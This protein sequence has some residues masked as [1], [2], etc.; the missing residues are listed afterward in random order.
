MNHIRTSILIPTVALLLLALAACTTTS[1][2]PPGTGNVNGYIVGLGDWS[3]FSPPLA[4]EAPHPDPDED[5]TV[6]ADATES[7]PIK[8]EDGEVVRD[9]TT[10]EPVG[11]EDV[12]YTCTTTPYNLTS[13][14]GQIVMYNPDASILWAGS[15]IQGESYARGIGG[16][17]GLTI[18]ERAPIEVV[19]T[20]FFNDN[21]SE[22]VANPSLGT[23][24]D[25][26][27]RMVGGATAENLATPSTIAFDM[28]TYHSE[29]DF[30]AAFNISGSYLGFSAAASGSIDNSFSKTTVA[31]NFRQQMF[32]VSVPPPQTPGSFFSSDFTQAKLQE[33]IDLGRIGPD[34]LPVYVSEIVYGRMMMFTLTSTASETELRAAISA[35]YNGIGSVSADLSASQRNVLDQS[36][37]RITSFGGEADATI[38][39][40]R[41]G[42]W[43]DYFTNSAPLTSAKPLS[44]TFRNLSDGSIAKVSETGSYNIRECSARI[45]SPGTFDFG[46]V[47]RTDD[48]PIETPYQTLVGDFDGD[49]HDDLLFNHLDPSSNEL[50]LAFGTGLGTFDLV[51][52]V[53]NPAADPDDPENEEPPFIDVPIYFEAHPDT[54]A[55]GWGNY[56]TR[57]MD[58]DGDDLDDVVWNVHIS[59]ANKTYA[60]IATVDADG[61]F[62]GFDFTEVS[63]HW[64]SAANGWELY[65]LLTGDINGDDRGDLVWHYRASDRTYVGL[66]NGDGSFD[67][68]PFQDGLTISSSAYTPFIGDVNGDIYADLLV[69]NGSGSVDKALGQPDGTFVTSSS[70]GIF[71]SGTPYAANIDANSSTDIV[72]LGFVFA[73]W[74]AQVGFADGG[75]DFDTSS[76]QQLPFV[77]DEDTVPPFFDPY[78]QDVNGDGNDDLIYT[79]PGNAKVFGESSNIKRIFVG[80][81]TSND[82][83]PFDISRIHQDH[84]QFLNWSTYS[85]SFGDV[86]GDGLTDIIWVFEGS[87][88]R[89]LVG[90]AKNE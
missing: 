21:P 67:T 15:L 90:L 58:I 2:P 6:L 43:R 33:Q 30:A 46:V 63:P 66:S 73:H 23:V 54:A 76:E 80:L 13:N 34:N 72:Y 57:I 64:N 75:G 11:F 89:I 26:I 53:P 12:T 56:E 49:D 41:S 14:P 45:A 32:T 9:D 24:T 28:Q 38:A 18:A 52:P 36:E 59:G 8:D 25:A 69:V 7:T 79:G 42:N 37:V 83:E 17:E 35:A 68:L 3:D 47:Q 50:M 78:F 39:M 10:G 86:N 85:T 62:A 55:E 87:T 1:G 84:P 22:V 71:S 31:V 20:D 16:L 44:Y 4:D 81:G 51:T 60:A 5:P 40:I 19:I 74:D 88:N 27:G 65:T 61:A 29:A 70:A 77:A 48:M 82:F